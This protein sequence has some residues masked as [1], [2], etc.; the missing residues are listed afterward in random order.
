[1]RKFPFFL[2]FLFF[3]TTIRGT[4]AQ[5]VAPIVARTGSA[6]E[7]LVLPGIHNAGKVSDN[8]FRGAQPDLPSLSVLKNLGVTTIVDLRG[9]SPETTRKERDAA[10][11][12]GLRF[13]SIPVGGFATPTD[14]QMA[15]FFSVLR[16][17]PAP[18]VFVHC[19]YG[20][21]RTGTFVAAY[22]MAFQNWTTDEAMTEMMTFGFH[23]TWHPAMEHYVQGFRT[24]LQNTAELRGAAAA[25]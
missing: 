14:S 11:A 8:L 25:R 17:S 21:D 10:T 4:A 19:E 24:R 6:A 18:I 1:M 20:R 9:D 5:T 16:E 7:K 12:L 15:E 2:L 23:R 3:L 13:V 22:R